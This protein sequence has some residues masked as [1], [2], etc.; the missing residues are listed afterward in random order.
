MDTESVIE[1]TPEVTDEV[2]TEEEITQDQRR[3]MTT[4]NRTETAN[5]VQDILTSIAYFRFRLGITDINLV[6]PEE[7][8]LWCFFARALAGEN[9]RLFADFSKLQ[10]YS[11]AEIFSK[12][13]V[14]HIR[15]AGDFRGA[16]L[17]QTPGKTLL[18]NVTPAF[19]ID[20]IETAFYAA[21]SASD[22]EL[23]PGSITADE[24]IDMLAPRRRP[25][26]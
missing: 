4:F 14:P 18:Y 13:F 6:C 1:E 10:A 19:S 2:V 5:R 22:L 25:K 20:W 7:A 9:I 16:A 3:Y 11:D 17:L 15:R 12:V 8:G 21:G 24:L 26:W 23:R